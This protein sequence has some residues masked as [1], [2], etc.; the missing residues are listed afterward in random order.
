MLWQEQGHDSGLVACSWRTL[1]GMVVVVELERY[2]QRFSHIYSTSR[3]LFL[4]DMDRVYTSIVLFSFILSTC[5]WPASS[6]PWWARL[7]SII[8][9]IITTMTAIIDFFTTITWSPSLPFFSLIITLATVSVTLIYHWLS[10]IWPIVYCIHMMYMI[11]YYWSNQMPSFLLQ[12]Q[13]LG[14]SRSG[15][16]KPQRLGK[17][18]TQRLTVWVVPSLEVSSWMLKVS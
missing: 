11:A 1:G 15:C 7:I 13:L 2:V 6:A 16:Y 18:T 17:T 4:E 3:S 8:G 14:L 5:G 10:S 12:I 9:I